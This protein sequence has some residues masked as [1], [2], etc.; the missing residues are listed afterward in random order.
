MCR[1]D[2]QRTRLDVHAAPEDVAVVRAA[3]AGEEHR[4]H[5]LGRVGVRVRVRVRVRD[6]VR[7][8]VRVTL[9]VLRSQKVSSSCR[10]TPLISPG[11]GSGFG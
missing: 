3:L 7:V 8:R 2:N 4:H 9:R 10:S 1:G 5:H 11:L 6:R